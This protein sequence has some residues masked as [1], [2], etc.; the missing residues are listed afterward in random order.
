LV[1]KVEKAVNN[2]R[3]LQELVM[4]AGERYT[5]ALKRE[6]KAKSRAGKKKGRR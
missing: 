6:R 2:G 4:E 5:K 3:L 1:G